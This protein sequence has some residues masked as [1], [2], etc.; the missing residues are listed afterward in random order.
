MDIDKCN[1]AD[2]QIEHKS[3][4]AHTSIQ[5][6]RHLF[7]LTLNVIYGKIYAA[8]ETWC[9]CYSMKEKSI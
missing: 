9:A 5:K 4:W 3:C 2:F 6:Y 8:V 1:S 7:K